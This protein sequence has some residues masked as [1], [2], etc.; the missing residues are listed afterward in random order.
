MSKNEGMIQDLSNWWGRIEQGYAECVKYRLTGSP[1]LL[2]WHGICMLFNDI[3]VH[4]GF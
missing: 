1:G 3:Q 2:H 4:Q